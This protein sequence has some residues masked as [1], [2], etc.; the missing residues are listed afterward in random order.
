MSIFAGLNCHCGV[1][2]YQGVQYYVTVRRESR[3]GWQHVK[4][5]GPYPEHDQALAA[6]PAATRLAYASGDLRAHWYHYG[7]AVC[8]NE[9]RPGMFTAAQLSKEA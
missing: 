8:W 2:H 6:L 5:A 9:R 1:S 4:L 3:E 7:T